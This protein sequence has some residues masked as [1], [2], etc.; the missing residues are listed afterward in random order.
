MLL[1][2]SGDSTEAGSGAAD[3]SGRESGG[4]GGGGAT[5]EPA[6]EAPAEPEPAPPEPEPAPVES[7]ELPSSDNP[8]PARGQSLNDEGFALL[9][10]GNPEEALPSLEAAVAAFPAGSEDVEYAYALFNYAQASRMTGNPEAAIPA[11]ERRLE[12][13]SDRTEVVRRELELA[14]EAAGE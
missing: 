3:R 2:G 9:Q 8:D 7:G 4:D 12:F 13:S 10:A 1:A 11:L 6:A 5:D 14:R